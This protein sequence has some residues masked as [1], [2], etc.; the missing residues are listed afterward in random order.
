M[1]LYSG[2]LA[3]FFERNPGSCRGTKKFFYVCVSFF[4]MALGPSGL[5]RGTHQLSKLPT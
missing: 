1:Y 2:F 5:R 4:D 3:F